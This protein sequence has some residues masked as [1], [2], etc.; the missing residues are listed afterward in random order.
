MYLDLWP[1][2][3]LG[4]LLVFLFFVFFELHEQFTC[5]GDEV[6]VGL[7]LLHFIPILRLSFSFLYVSQRSMRSFLFTFVLF[8]ITLSGRSKKNF[9]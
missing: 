1:V 9:L 8:F 7:C 5:F 2:F 3:L 6:Q 4:L